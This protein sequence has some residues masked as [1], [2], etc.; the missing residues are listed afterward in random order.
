MKLKQKKRN[1]LKNW[2]KNLRNNEEAACRGSFFFIL[3]FL[4]GTDPP[5]QK[6]K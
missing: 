5:V 1:L 4:N 3:I 6:E 2:K